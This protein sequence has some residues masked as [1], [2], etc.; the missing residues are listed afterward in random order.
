MVDFFTLKG[1][2]GCQTGC[3]EDGEYI[4]VKIRKMSEVAEILTPSAI[5]GVKLVERALG[6]CFD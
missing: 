1:I 2:D 3:H 6:R 4:Q 5:I